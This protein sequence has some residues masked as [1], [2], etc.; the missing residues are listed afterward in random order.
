MNIPA[1]EMLFEVPSGQHKWATF[2]V[3]KKPLTTDDERSTLAKLENIDGTV[4]RIY[5]HDIKEKYTMYKGWDDGVAIFEPHVYD[6][7]GHDAPPI[8]Q[9]FMGF[10][11]FEEWAD[12][13]AVNW[14]S[15]QE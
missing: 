1:P 14:W 2:V 11:T 12:L 7:S 13:G 10:D 4:R 5:A 6:D 3:G 8:V 9:A 15:S